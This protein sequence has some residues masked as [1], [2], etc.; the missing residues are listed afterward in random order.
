MTKRPDQH[1][2]DQNEAQATDYKF[3]RQTEDQNRRGGET[4]TL[5][6]GRG[7]SGTPNETMQARREQS[8]K[9]RERELERAAGVK[10]R[11][12]GNHS[13]SGDEQEP[14]GDRSDLRTSGASTGEG[15]DQALGKSGPK[16]R[17]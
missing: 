2:L 3:R 4:E 11:G 1:N 14:E 10:E 6:G 12:E 9:D 16:P 15:T 5:E 8:E 7:N 13:S 17:E